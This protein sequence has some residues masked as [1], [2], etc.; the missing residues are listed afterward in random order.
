MLRLPGVD[1][2][3]VEEFEKL[4]ENALSAAD[5]FKGHPTHFRTNALDRFYVDDIDFVLACFHSKEG[6]IK[7]DLLHNPQT[8]SFAYGYDLILEDGQKKWNE[9]NVLNICHSFDEGANSDDRTSFLKVCTKLDD[10]CTDKQM[11]PSFKIIVE[12]I[13]NTPK[14]Q[15]C[16]DHK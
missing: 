15:F 13:F 9:Q 1:A 8:F 7:R 10:S 16:M 6:F 5:V 4:G 2:A 14:P 12:V 3:V 11:V